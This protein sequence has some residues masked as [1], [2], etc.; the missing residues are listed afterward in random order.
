M[1]LPKDLRSALSPNPPTGLPPPGGA[2]AIDG[3]P[4]IREEFGSAPA[5]LEANLAFVI[6]SLGGDGMDDVY[7]AIQ[8]ECHKLGLRAK[9]VDDNVGSGFV[10]KEIG[11]LIEQAEF[12]ICDLTHERP[13]VYYELGYAHGVG[14]K[15][16]NILLIAN[17]ETRL[18]FDIAPL[19][20]RHYRSIEE[21]RAL[22]ARNL[23][24]MIKIT[25]RRRGVVPVPGDTRPNPRIWTPPSSKKRRVRRSAKSSR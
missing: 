1:A 14:N 23:V 10:M 18:H 9:R 6:M 19:R 25:R 12:I 20:V 5:P 17:R 24:E 22:L 13:N 8:D 15:S 2:P 11:T 16:R 21:L 3:T 7:R 4:F